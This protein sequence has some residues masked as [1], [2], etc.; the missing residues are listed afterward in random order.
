MQSPEKQAKPNKDSLKS[1]LK[2]ALYSALAAVGIAGF[3]MIG[4]EISQQGN[5]SYLLSGGYCAVAEHGYNPEGSKVFWAGKERSINS[6]H[7]TVFNGY[8]SVICEL[9]GANVLLDTTGMG[10][11]F[12]L[13]GG[14]AIHKETGIKLF[15]VAPDKPHFLLNTVAED[16]SKEL[17]AKYGKY[18]ISAGNMM[19]LT[20]D[21]LVLRDFGLTITSVLCI[22]LL[23]ST[24]RLAYVASDKGAELEN[25]KTQIKHVSGE[26]DKGSRFRDENV[27]LKKDLS[28]WRNEAEKAR[29]EL[30]EL[31]NKP[32]AV[33]IVSGAAGKR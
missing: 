32:I 19:R 2:I 12:V 14:E 21:S 16:T 11:E 5:R 1:R 30:K 13:T 6:V 31:K 7:R 4:N 17:I 8:N 28:F 18:L 22:V 23:A 24:A 15:A 33:R 27:R 20:P 26:A 10:I 29:A 9:D 25:A 3:A